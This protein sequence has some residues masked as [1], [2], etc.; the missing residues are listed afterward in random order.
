VESLRLNFTAAIEDASVVL[1]PICTTGMPMAGGAYGYSAS[2]GM[3]TTL[4]AY[5]T[6][7]LA[8]VYQRQ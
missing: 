1:N 5:G 2:A 4:T 6:T 7:V 3:L 8:R